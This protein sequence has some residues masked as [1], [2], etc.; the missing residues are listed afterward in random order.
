M[1]RLQLLRAAAA[2]TLAIALAPRTAPAQG[3]DTLSISGTFCMDQH[4]DQL[5]G[6]V[7]ADLSAV[8]SRGNTHTWTLTLHGVS[9][10]HD[11]ASYTRQV[12]DEYAGEYDVFVEEFT[13]GVH[14]TSFD[15]EF[16]G[17]DADVLNA[18]VSSQLSDAYFDV[19]NVREFYDG[20]Y[21]DSWNLY[22]T[23]SLALSP[24]DLDAGVAFIGYGDSI[25]ELFST[26]P[27]GYPVV[28]PRLVGARP[29]IISDRR[30][31]NGGDWRS[32]GDL[33]DIGASVPPV[34]PPPPPPPPPPPTLSIG[35]GSVREGNRDTTR[36][37]LTVM[38]SRSI[39]DAVTVNYATANGT[40]Q[41]KSDYS[42]TSG[43]LTFP[44]GE[45]SRTISIAIKTDRKRE[46]NETFSVQLSNAVGATISDGTATATIVN[47]D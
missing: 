37:D 30:P 14:A 10:S 33:V 3:A 18:V 21:Y 6:R 36:L 12:S 16:F 8:F 23:W 41:A 20:V 34:L 4:L 39:A 13:T 11:V 46:K 32:Y 19:R 22:S 45:T 43:T 26:D 38:L 1:K 47:D 17:P 44:A 29:L 42:A 2:V 15:F 9:Y 27:S 28:E 7:G 24:P 5:Y 40:A 31:G 25:Y 35:D